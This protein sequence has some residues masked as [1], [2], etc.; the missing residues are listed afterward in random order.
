MAFGH[1]LPPPM[2][3]TVIL[4]LL[5]AIFSVDIVM[6]VG[7]PLGV[8]Y[9]VPVYFTTWASQ[10]SWIIG[11]PSVASGLIVAVY[12]L[13]PQEGLSVYATL[14][15]LLAIV[16]LWMTAGIARLHRHLRQ[17][18]EA[19]MES[20]EERI[21]H[22]T[23]ELETSNERL[24][25]LNRLKSAFVSVASHEIRTPITS[26]K[27]YT[28]NLLDHLA[29]PL[30]ERQHH[31][32][33]RIM[34]NINRLM[35]II[36]ELLNLATIEAGQVTVHRESFAI[37]ALFSEA[38]ESFRPAASAKGITIE[39]ATGEEDLYVMA[40]KDKL[41]Q[42][43]TN[44][45]GN[46]VKFT[47]RGGHVQV[48]AVQRGSNVEITVSDNG[49]GIAAEELPRIF[50]RFYRGHN[51]MNHEQGAGLGLAI[52]KTLVE[53]H[54]G[55]INVESQLGKGSRFTIPMDAQRGD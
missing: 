34:T 48:A 43:F 39:G 2:L 51:G 36:E 45:L 29:G 49:T 6:P 8:L 14:N 19:V 31:Y 41:R 50:D 25:E 30:T 52:A 15:H 21:R 40:D 23:Q 22:R 47:P 7:L 44:L 27:G 20:L 55:R 24:Q 9:I 33:S 10:R 11:V 5:F 54:G 4:A 35:N 37:R 53:L 28:E 38:L 32:L 1:L 18:V 12:F 13:A 17:Q 42:A 46:A 26:I 16:V 3:H